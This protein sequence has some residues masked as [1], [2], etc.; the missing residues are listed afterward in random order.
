M[1][2][3][4]SS[5]GGS[6][7]DGLVEVLLPIVIALAVILAAGAWCA[8]RLTGHALPFDPPA[9]LKA[10]FHFHHPANAWPHKWRSQVPSPVTYWMVSGVIL[11]AVLFVFSLLLVLWERHKHRPPSGTSTS[12]RQLSDKEIAKLLRPRPPGRAQKYHW[13][14]RG[15]Q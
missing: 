10:L 3:S 15:R 12:P 4:G 8:A 13:W 14:S 9:A 11:I 7:F 2:G 5:G 6:T 1:D